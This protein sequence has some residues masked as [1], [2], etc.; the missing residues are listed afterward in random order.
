V[1]K[2]EIQNSIKDIVSTEKL[3]GFTIFACL[4]EE[5]GFR[6]KKINATNEL[7]DCARDRISESIIH[8]Y[9]SDTAEFD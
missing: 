4:R 2:E 5:N 3:C 6:A 8:S 9:L 7:I 1:N